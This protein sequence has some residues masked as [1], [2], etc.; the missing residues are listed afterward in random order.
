MKA[1]AVATGDA[2]HATVHFQCEQLLAQHGTRQAGARHKLIHG[3]DA[4]AKVP[5]RAVNP[6]LY[7][8]LVM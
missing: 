8:R 1:T 2:L 6:G 5:Q 4:A 7:G 3:V